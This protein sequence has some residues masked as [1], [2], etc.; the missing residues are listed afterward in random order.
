MTSSR[1]ELCFRVEN[2]DGIGMY[3]YRIGSVG[4]MQDGQRR[5]MPYEDAMLRTAWIRLADDMQ[6]SYF[7]FGFSS[8]AQLRNWIHDERIL[9]DLAEAGFMLA[10]YSCEEYYHGDTQMIFRHETAE[11]VGRTQLT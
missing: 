3:R 2:A 5:P 4:S 6:Q 8:V 11:L 10:V 7:R 9:A 1:R